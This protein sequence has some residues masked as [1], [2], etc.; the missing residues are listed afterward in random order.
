MLL[1]A[2]GAIFGM[3]A[4][5]GLPRFHHPLFGNANFRRASDDK[6][7]I[8]VEVRDPNYDKAREAKKWARAS[9]LCFAMSTGKP[10]CWAMNAGQLKSGC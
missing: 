3:L 9:R 5:N 2:F 1:S 4:I 10:S 7:F 8:A 6:F